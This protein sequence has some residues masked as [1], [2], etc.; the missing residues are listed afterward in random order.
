[1]INKMILIGLVSV[2]MF[3]VKAQ[4]AHCHISDHDATLAIIGEAE[5]QG[6]KGMQA[7]AHAIRNRGTLKG[8]YG[9]HA[10]RVTKKL[11]SPSTFHNASLAWVGSKTEQDFTHGATH[12]EAVQRYGFPSWARNMIATIKIKDHTFFKKGEV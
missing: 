10:P 12:W 7:V 1:M 2:G 5:D 9:L 6:Y 11:F 4:A 8:V 3:P